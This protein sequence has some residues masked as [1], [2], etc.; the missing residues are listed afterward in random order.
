[1]RKTTA[2]DEI[3]SVVKNITKERE[4]KQ[5]RLSEVLVYMKSNKTSFKESTIRTHITSK[6]CSNAPNHHGMVFNDYERIGRG[7]YRVI[8]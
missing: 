8:P 3:L 7:L 5:F 4:E 2:R 6:C 1:M